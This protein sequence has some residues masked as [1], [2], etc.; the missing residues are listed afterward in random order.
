MKEEF[1]TKMHAEFLEGEM[2]T[3]D[4]MIMGVCGAMW[5]YGSLKRAL[6][7]YPEI[8]KEIFFDNVARVMDKKST[9]EFIKSQSKFIDV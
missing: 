8:T 2:S 6:Q 5:R 9:E 3:Q 1:T 7:D 4:V